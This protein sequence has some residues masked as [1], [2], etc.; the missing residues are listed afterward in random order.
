MSGSWVKK[1]TTVKFM[2]VHERPVVETLWYT[3]RP[4]YEWRAYAERNTFHAKFM[5]GSWAGYEWM[6]LGA[7]DS[8]NH[9][10]HWYYIFLGT[11]PSLLASKT[12]LSWASHEKIIR[13]SWVGAINSNSTRFVQ[14]DMRSPSFMSGLWE[15]YEW[16]MS[17]QWRG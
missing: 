2:R 17:R 11:W 13:G 9:I 5:S 3:S 7:P 10:R 16:F 8:W 15:V 4:V 14:T 12:K 6:I 1:T